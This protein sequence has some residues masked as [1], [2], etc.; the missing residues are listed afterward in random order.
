M[1]KIALLI[2]T[3]GFIQAIQS[4]EE[5]KPF[6][7]SNFC[8]N[9]EYQSMYNAYTHLV[10]QRDRYIQDLVKKGMDPK[11]AEKRYQQTLGELSHEL[12]KSRN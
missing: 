9:P 3:C 1:K 8:P 10:T 5:N 11:D 6:T 12:T 2:F 7:S 4:S